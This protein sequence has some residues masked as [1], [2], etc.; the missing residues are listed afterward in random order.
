LETRFAAA[1]GAVPL[2]VVLRG[3]KPDR[4][5]RVARLLYEAGVRLMEV[6]LNS[7]RP[8][9]SIRLARAAV[10][11]EVLVGAGTVLRPSDVKDAVAAGAE[12]LVMPNLDPDVMAAGRV[13]GV[14]LMPG[15]MTPSEAF[16]AVALGASVLKLF[17]AEVVGPAG[18][19]ALRAVL[20]SD[21]AR[22]FPVGGVDCQTMPRW[23]EAG[24]DGFGVGGS[25]FKPEFTDEE[26]F[27]RAK[28]LVGGCI[29][30]VGRKP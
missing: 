20:P 18:L 24:A 29:E 9:E 10:P 11:G 19:K 7:P 25:L 8:L 26:I 13:T 5:T 15:V 1:V 3:L 30:A 27:Q 22:I 28:D 21:M 16:A 6:T 14:P 12:F 2:V 17:P 4:A 23:V